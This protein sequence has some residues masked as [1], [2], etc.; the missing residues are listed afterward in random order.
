MRIRLHLGIFYMA[1]FTM[2]LNGNVQATPISVYSNDFESSVGSEWS[3]S[4]CTGPCI[5]Y[6]PTIAS[7][8]SGRN[9]LT[10]NANVSAPAGF[11]NQRIKLNLGMLPTHDSMTLSFDLYLI[12]DWRGDQDINGVDLFGAY[13]QTGSPGDFF[14]LND[15]F[16]NWATFSQSYPGNLGV[17]H[18]AGRTGAAENNTLGYQI[19]GT[20]G[21]SVYKFNF[22]FSHSLE[23]LELTFFGKGL[24]PPG[25]CCGPS[26]GWGLDNVSVSVSTTPV[27]EPSSLLLM[28]SGLLVM[29][30]YVWRREGVQRS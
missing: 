22:T 2:I 21:D 6:S 27:P 17:D 1:I 9:F 24:L 28:G 23:T 12:K 11:N 25:F 8:P 20:G 5:N 30:L 7:T 29:M 3:V 14:L 26:G 10:G 13:F 16:S 18:F 19:I 4:S 15:T